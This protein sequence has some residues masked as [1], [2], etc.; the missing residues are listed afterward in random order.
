MKERDRYAIMK[1][2]SYIAQNGMD[3]GILQ[4][5]HTTNKQGRE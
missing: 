5:E 2:A 4:A 3:I 1:E